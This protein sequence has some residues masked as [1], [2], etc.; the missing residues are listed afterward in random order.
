MKTLKQL[1][2]QSPVYLNDWSSKFA[3]MSDFE[4]LYMSEDEYKAEKS[5]YPNEKLWLEKK[6]KVKRLLPEWKKKN[7]LFASYGHANYE[8]RAW[9][10]FEQNGELFEINASHCSCYGLEGQWSP[11]KVV[12]QELYNR[13]EKGT[14][15]HDTW[16]GNQFKTELK[17]F[18]GLLN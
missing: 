10:L 6:D 11:E 5:P 17:Q 3:V 7:I 13:V 2:K 15:G 4:D 1:L 9:V 18:L 12:L 8:G 16:S 14:F